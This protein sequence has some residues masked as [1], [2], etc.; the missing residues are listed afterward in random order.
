M[1]TKLEDLDAWCRREGVTRPEAIRRFL[2]LGLDVS[3]S[4]KS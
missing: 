3:Q 1:V 2:R 4:G